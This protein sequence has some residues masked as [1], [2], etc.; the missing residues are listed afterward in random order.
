MQQKIL[1]TT[2]LSANSK[3]GIR[4]AIQLASQSSLSPIF[5]YV[6][7]PI[8]PWDPDYISNR[9]A[10][11]IQEGETR[12]RRF[13]ADVYRE[14]DRRPRKLEYVVVAGS[15][16]DR[17]IVDYAVKRRVK[18]ICISTR[19][20]G[21]VRRIIGTYTSAVIKLSPVPV[22]AIPKNYRRAPVESV[23]YASDLVDFKQELQKVKK[24]SATIKASVSVLHYD[25]F[26]QIKDTKQEFEK[27]SKR[28]D[29]TD[30]SFHLQRFDWEKT[31]ASHIKAAIR[32]YKPSII[33]FFTRQD[34]NWY[35]RIFLSSKTADI[36][37]DTKRPILVFPK[38]GA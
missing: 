21:R 16:V 32:K 4:F 19:G 8:T 23:M 22:F 7:E 27:I 3:A 25:A 17:A 1:V 5:F 24:F 33:A 10:G 36:T 9:M 34:R 38:E 31:L 35:Q 29:A 2:D 26:P 11:E 6:I 28:Y 12:L 30:V 20:A 14:F 37:Y 13:V 18:F 15:P